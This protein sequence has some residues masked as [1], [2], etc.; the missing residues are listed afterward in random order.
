MM[1]PLTY[2]KHLVSAQRLPFTAAY[3]GS[4]GLTLYFSLGVSSGLCLSSLL[5]VSAVLERVGGEKIWKGYQLTVLF[6]QY[7]FEAHS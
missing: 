1:G 5:F 7:S 2:G 6:L 3:F 4:I